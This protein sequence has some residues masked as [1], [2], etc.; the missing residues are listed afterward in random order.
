MRIVIV[1][2][3]SWG[4]V[5]PNGVLGQALQQA[6]YRVVLVAAESFR[7]WV[8]K[9]GLTFTGLSFNIQAM[10]D[11]QSNN[12]NLFQ[13]MRWMRQMTNTMVQM[14]REIADV[15]QDGDAVLVSEGMTALVSGIV[16]KKNASLIHIN[17]QPWVPTSEFSGMLPPPPTWI[18]IQRAAYN[19]WAGSFVRR[20]QWW[21]M[22]KY[23]NQ[24]RTNYLSLPK[25]TWAKHSTLLNSA[26]SLLLVSPHVIPPPA[27]WPL[28]HHVT[29]YIFD[30]ESGWQPPQDLQDFLAGGDRPVYIGFG[31]MHERDPEATT[32]IILDAV[33]Q[34][35]KRAVLLSGWAGIGAGGLPEDVF[36]LKY[37]P[38]D[39]LFPHMAAAVHHGGAGTTAAGLRA[40]VPSVIVPMMSDQPFWGRRVHELGAGTQPIP[41]SKLTAD[42]L[43]AAITQAATNRAMREKASEL[44]AKIR[45]EDGSGEAVNAIQEFL[46]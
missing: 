43:A 35:G 6:G 3:G 46:G 44:G 42:N 45:A 4:D 22:G 15:I 11:E 21:A 18:P 26:P 14:G 8:E 23:G 34:A 38:H 25:Q 20:S 32:R 30:N 29:G 16:E 36:L 24:I 10:L 39:W 31:S 13:T 19:R 41:R 9:R 28:Q 5:R 2:T 12:R 37:A 17:L 1:A 27:D 33:K 7:Q 40:G